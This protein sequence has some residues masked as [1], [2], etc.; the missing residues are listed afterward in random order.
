MNEK[1][2]TPQEL[3]DDFSEWHRFLARLYHRRWWI[4]GGL[5]LVGGVVIYWLVGL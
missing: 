2:Y 4:G 5:V 1:Y 3:D